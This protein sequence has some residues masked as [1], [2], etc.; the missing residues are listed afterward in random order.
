MFTTGQDVKKEAATFAQQAE[1]F[2]ADGD[3]TQAR[4]AAAQAVS[5]EPK[6][7]YA[8]AQ[9]G[10]ALL[11]LGQPR[12]AVTAFQVALEG[13]PDMAVLHLLLGN[14]FRAAGDNAHAVLPYE[15]TVELAPD[16]AGAWR[17]LG[18]ALLGVGRASEAT[19]KLRHACALEP[20]SAASW[21]SLGAALHADGEVPAA[22]CAFAEAARNAGADNREG[23]RARWNESLLRLLTGDMARGWPLY[24]YR[25]DGPLGGGP[26]P[27]GLRFLTQMP[28]P[29]MRVLVTVEQ[30]LG[31]II[32]IL[33]F[34]PLLAAKGVRIVMQR[35]ATMRRLLADYP[36]VE[37]FLDEGEPVPPVD[38]VLPCMSL[39][40]LF[41]TNAGYVPGTVPYLR[42][43]PAL[44]TRWEGRLAAASGLRVGF[45][46]AGNPDN[47]R[48]LERSLK[49][50]QVLPLMGISGLNPVVVQVGGGRRELANHPLPPGTIDLGGEIADLADTVAILSRLDVLVSCCTL[51]AH[52]A[53]AVGIA[54]NILITAVP[55]WRWGLK[56]AGTAWYPSARLFRQPRPGDWSGPLADLAGDLSMRIGAGRRP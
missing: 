4:M 41:V 27:F 7:S 3:A 14:A 15:R 24:A 34:L 9:L 52:L 36:G 6:N 5:L 20:T 30:G 49:L 37:S 39:P 17:N 26:V 11:R 46:W 8:Q 18:L 10:Q 53:G 33:R 22:L 35:P 44:A 2:L 56:H 42:A 31:D 54:T 55:D 28:E 32:M 43:D 12:E 51:P 48:D 21:N 19:V 23:I 29:G 47:A 38:G 13:A 50:E 40:G 45:V 16:M 1:R 25:R